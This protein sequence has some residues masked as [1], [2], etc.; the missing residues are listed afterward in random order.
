M[1]SRRP[2]GGDKRLVELALY[3]VVGLVFRVSKQGP[4]LT[5]IEEDGG[6]KRLVELA[7]YP[8]VGLVF[9]VSKQGPRLTIIVENGGDER[10][11][12]LEPACKADGVATPDP[13]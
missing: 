5:A 2:N 6:D 10:L 7:L 13:V 11:V 1:I 3:P 12:E 4:G 8:V 9:R